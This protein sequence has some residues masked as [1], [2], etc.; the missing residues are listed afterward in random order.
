MLARPKPSTTRSWKNCDKKTKPVGS[1]ECRAPDDRSTINPEMKMAKIIDI[2][3]RSLVRN[4]EKLHAQPR[5]SRPDL[6]QL[7]GFDNETTVKHFISTSRLLPWVMVDDNTEGLLVRIDTELRAICDGLRHRPALPNAF[8]IVD[9]FAHLRQT[10]TARRIENQDQRRKRGWSPEAIVTRF[11][12]ELL[13]W[14]EDE[15]DRVSVL[16]QPAKAPKS[17]RSGHRSPHSGVKGD[18]R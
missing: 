6:R 2:N 11:Q 13:D 17:G 8:S 1:D 5:L 9:F 16:L 14:I 10:I 15:L 4:I 18:R 3:D 12:T 7:C